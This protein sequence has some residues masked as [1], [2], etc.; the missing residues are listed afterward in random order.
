[1][2]NDPKDT[3]VDLSKLLKNQSKNGQGVNVNINTQSMIT[4]LN[5]GTTMIGVETSTKNSGENPL[6]SNENFTKN[7]NESNN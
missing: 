3:V 2:S 6:R 1:M 4:S 5:E 7:K